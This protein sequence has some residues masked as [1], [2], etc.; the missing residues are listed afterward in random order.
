MRAPAAEDRVIRGPTRPWTPAI[1]PPG[2]ARPPRHQPATS[3]SRPMITS[4][5]LISA[6]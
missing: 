3:C 1:Y 6:P 2:R 5:L 4:S